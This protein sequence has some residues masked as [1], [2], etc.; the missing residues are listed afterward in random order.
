MKLDDVEVG[1]EYA[2]K[3]SKYNN[4]RKVLLVEKRVS[5]QVYGEWHAHTSERPLAVRIKMMTGYSET[6]EVLPRYLIRTWKE[7]EVVNE[8]AA[9]QQQRRRDAQADLKRMLDADAADGNDAL[10]GI[11]GSFVVL[12]FGIAL[13]TPHWK[14]QY[15]GNLEHLAARLAELHGAYNG[16]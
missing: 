16:E 6:R 10:E 12:N 4:A 1:V 13:S 8:A 15:R 7:Q 5:H 2:Y 14:L 9:E 3:P 11:D